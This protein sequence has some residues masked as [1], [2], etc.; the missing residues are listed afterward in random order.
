MTWLLNGLILNGWMAL[1]DYILETREIPLCFL[2]FDFIEQYQVTAGCKPANLYGHERF[3]NSRART[4]K[5]KSEITPN[6]SRWKN[7]DRCRG[8]TGEYVSTMVVFPAVPAAV[9]S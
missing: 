1:C 2:F 3:A 9:I 8:F 7:R 4:D 6:A 5:V